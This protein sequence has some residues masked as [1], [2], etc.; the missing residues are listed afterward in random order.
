MK[1]TFIMKDGAEKTINFSEGQTLMEA[2][3]ENNIPLAGACE[4]FGVCG[5]CH[6]VVENFQDKLPEISDDEADTLDKIPGVTPRSRL[7]CKIILNNSIS[8]L[9]VRIFRHCT[10]SEM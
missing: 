1:I 2:A 6:V 5:G 7:A 9:R 10:N 3:M 4:G 8:G